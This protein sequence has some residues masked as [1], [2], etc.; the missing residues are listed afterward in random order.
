[1]PPVLGWLGGGL[2]SLKAK[3][4]GAGIIL[5]AVLLF[6]WR[7]RVRAYASGR[8]DTIAAT[9]EKTIETV[10]TATAVRDRVGSAG[11]AEL[12]RMRDRWT[13]RQ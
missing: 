2:A 7:V 8:Q 4:I 5:G 13:R 11:R 9:W 6:I 10:T 3:L 12:D 1:M